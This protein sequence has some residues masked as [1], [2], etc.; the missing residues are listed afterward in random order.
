MNQ[1]QIVLSSYQPPV[2]VTALTSSSMTNPTGSSTPIPATAKRGRNDTSGISESNMQLRTQYVQPTHIF[3]SSNTPNKRL[4]GVNPQSNEV[5]YTNQVRHNVP[6]QPNRN[7]TETRELV[8]SND[9]EQVPSTAA[10]RFVSTRYPL[11]PFSV[12]FSQK[13]REKTVVDDLI[14]HGFDNSNF[15]LKAVA[16]RRER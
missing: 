4:R 15:E 16:Y 14:K 12:I 1:Q 2:N 11:A 7:S 10:C 8:D 6:I 9:K 3:N 5:I 13:V